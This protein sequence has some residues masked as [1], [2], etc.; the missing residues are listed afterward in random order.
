MKAKNITILLMLAIGSV[1]G[2]SQ[3]L[4]PNGFPPLYPVS[5][6]V[7]QDGQPLGGALVS[8]H[9]TKDSPLKWGVFATTD[10]NG[11]AIFVTHGKFYGAPEGDYLITVEKGEEVQV[12][13]KG[14]STT[15]EAFTF[16]EK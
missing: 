6:L 10:S 12:A 14:D 9:G 15:T 4:K 7:V 13:K 3:Q 11:K 5:I 8:L 16:I 1:V 2:C